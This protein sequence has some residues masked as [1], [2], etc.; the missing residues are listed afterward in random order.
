MVA[1]S[2]ITRYNRKRIDVVK[3]EFLDMS[4]YQ[5]TDCGMGVKGMACGTCGAL[6]HHNTIQTAE[7]KKVQVSECPKGCGKIKSPQCCG[8]DMKVKHA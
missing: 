7:G 4:E 8:H 3:K 6:L 1:N 2:V 5:C